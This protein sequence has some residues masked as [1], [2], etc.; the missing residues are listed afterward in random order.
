MRTKELNKKMQDSSDKSLSDV[1]EKLNSKVD[2][3]GQ[4][5][6]ASGAKKGL[7]GDLNTG[8]ESLSENIV[9]SV[10]AP[11]EGISKGIDSLKDS[12]TSP[13]KSMKKFI[14]APF[15]GLEL[16][17]KLFGK[18]KSDVSG[19]LL[20]PLEAI[21][22]GINELVKSGLDAIPFI[23]TTNLEIV[24]NTDSISE[25]HKG[26]S[27]S[28]NSIDKS[29]TENNENATTDRLQER[30][31]QKDRI[32]RNEKLIGALKNLGNDKEDSE[33]EEKGF[34][35]SLISGLAGVIT[36]G[37]TAAVGVL[38][39]GGGLSAA[40]SALI[41]PLSGVIATV[42]GALSSIGTVISG[43][44][45]AFS[46]I[47][48]PLTIAI[49]VI[50]GIMGSIKGFK[51]EGF[52]GALKGF[53]SGALDAVVGS[54]VKAFSGITEFVFSLI[55]LG[56]LGKGIADTLT[57]LYEVLKSAIVGIVDIFKGLFTGDFELI[58]ETIANTFSLLG[59]TLKNLF[60]GVIP[61]AGKAI[62][63]IIK[64]IGVTLPMA[65]GKAV[66]SGLEVLLVD[67]PIMIGKALL[68]TLKVLLVDLPIFI[69]EMLLKGITK[70]L[71]LVFVDMPKA[72]FGFL[73]SI[74]EKI[75][76]FLKEAAES[77]IGF[78]GRI[79]SAIGSALAALAPGGKSPKEAFYESLNS[80]KV[81]ASESVKDSG[82]APVEENTEKEAFKA[83]RDSGLYD[84]DR[85]G[86]SEIDRSKLEGA[87]RAQL[88]AII[89]HDD[90]SEE[91]MEAVKEALKVKKSQLATPISAAK[92]QTIEDKI[93]AQPAAIAAGAA[94]SLRSGEVTKSEDVLVTDEYANAMVT[95]KEAK[96]QLEEFTST[97]GSFKMVDGYDG[98]WEEKVYDDPKQQEKYLELTKAEAKAHNEKKKQRDKIVGRQLGDPH[99][100]ALDHLTPETLPGMI[101]NETGG[102]T[103][104]G[105]A[106]ILN[107]S[108]DNY[109]DEQAE[110]QIGLKKQFEKQEALAPIDKIE[111]EASGPVGFLKRLFGQ[112]SKDEKTSK[113]SAAAIPQLA[114]RF[115]ALHGKQLDA[116][117]LAVISMS[118]TGTIKYA[119]GGRIRFKGLQRALE[120]GDIT[121]EQFIDHINTGLAKRGF[122]KQVN[123]ASLVKSGI[124]EAESSKSGS[125]MQNQINETNAIK[126]INEEARA[127]SAGAS[128]VVVQ[129]GNSN[130]VTNTTINSENHIDRTMMNFAYGV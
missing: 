19:D 29:L 1:I 94:Q 21:Q 127:S 116:K 69:G 101:I 39:A 71:E 7:I 45:S 92:P 30:E 53:I 12:V 99:F 83:A 17:K 100:F 91:D 64:F 124:L 66:L 109:L 26:N 15:K 36:G 59:D 77:V 42:G 126:S 56:D 78:F 88:N 72:I 95:L 13:F 123:E 28:L 76:G 82:G 90:L 89:N 25:L 98:M 34:F 104:N 10:K 50:G 114:K 40:F 129:G 22:K 84:F 38:F 14:S 23:A 3:L 96:R 112:D 51:E 57:S 128:N 108:I 20:K 79:P 46:K 113:S 97:A 105:N 111:K 107:N 120:N 48:F 37:I 60:L 81:L 125:Q 35:S 9:N 73:K 27:E 65:L 87:S 24:K 121:R 49:G 52:V 16:G 33:E 5:V 110:G 119:K 68:N 75:M 32:A 117:T 43:A 41:A 67:L 102:K 85:L 130:Q 6:K 118:R 2:T 103:F 115:K 58:K 70:S 61:A 80:G 106:G 31:L 47:L 18:G 63:G 11:F 74:P 122:E 4:E 86:K 54:V 62:L 55:G 44:L 8:L 93:P